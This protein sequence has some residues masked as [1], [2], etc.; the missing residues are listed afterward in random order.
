MERDHFYITLFSN[1]YQLIY[2]ENKI[3]AFTIQLAQPIIIIIPSYIWEVG[4]W[5]L[6][7]S[8]RQ[9]LADNTFAL[10]YCDRIAPQLI[11][12]NNV[13]FFRTF[14]IIMPED[15]GGEYQFENVYYVHVEKRMFRDIRIEILNLPCERVAFKDSKTPLNMVLHFRR[16]ITH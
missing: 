2:P 1:A 10:V 14:N 13:R 6:Y 11:G 7:F 15:Y 9:L 8:A 5:D 3:A 16:I 12:T 4:L